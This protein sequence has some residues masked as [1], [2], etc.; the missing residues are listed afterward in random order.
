M[1]RRIEKQVT[2][3]EN[4]QTLIERIGGAESDSHVLQSYKSGLAA[5]KSVFKENGL[6][7]DAVSDTMLEM[8][9]VC[10]F[11]KSY[12]KKKDVIF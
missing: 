12:V 2:V 9:D 10:I 8:T 11:F 6:T 5:L 1:E 3:L 7:E 4:V